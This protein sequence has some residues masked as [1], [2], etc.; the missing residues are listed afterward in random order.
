MN[1]PRRWKDSP[2]APVGVRE[3]L[4]AARPSRV[5]PEE[6]FARGVA[7]VAQRTA[8]PVAAATAIGLW[9]KI[10]IAGVALVA[11]T[12][13]VVGVRVVMAPEAQHPLPA[14]AQTRPVAVA[15]M[16]SAV[17]VATPAPAPEPSVETV[18]APPNR[19]QAASVQSASVQNA[20]VRTVPVAAAPEPVAVPVPAPEPVAREAPQREAST[21]ASELAL[22]ETA[23]RAIARDPARALADVAQHRARFPSGALGAE[24]DLVELEALKRLGRNDE[25]KARAD[26]WLAREPAG[27]YA[28]RVK[29]IRATLE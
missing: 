27:V 5:I 8:V 16:A 9:T 14:E 18:V 29:T 22:L 25:A 15:P 17:P 28:Q 19:V 3:L 13:S 21:L 26:A 4:S 10:A 23:Q 11:V 7:K 1:A 12:G 20:N 2:N 6:T 24:R